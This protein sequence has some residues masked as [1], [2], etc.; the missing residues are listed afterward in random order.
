MRQLWKTRG[1]REL[2]YAIAARRDETRFLCPGCSLKISIGA[3]RILG[4]QEVEIIGQP[5]SRIFTPEA[6]ERGKPGNLRGFSKIMQDITQRKQ[7]EEER[8]QLLIREQV[9]RAEAEAANRSKDEFLA[10]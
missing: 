9:A 10:V 7:V 4:Y 8:Q 1:E 2:F 3:E 5:F 6:I